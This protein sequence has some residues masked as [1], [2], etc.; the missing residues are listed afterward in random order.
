MSVS[1]SLPILVPVLGFFLS[2]TL[3]SVCCLRR[4]MVA[5]YENLADRVLA[6]EHKTRAQQAQQELVQ[7]TVTVPSA[8]YPSYPAYSNYQQP[9]APPVPYA[10]PFNPYAPKTY[11]V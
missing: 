9:S 3:T 10:Q 11:S 2:I 6:L 5:R 8:T 1:D 4:N 7:T